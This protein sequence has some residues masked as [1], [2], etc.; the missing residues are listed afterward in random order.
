MEELIQYDL[1]TME[2][3]L[4]RV[5]AFF[6]A[7]GIMLTKKFAGEQSEQ[8]EEVDA[9]QRIK[10]FV[11]QAGAPAFY[12]DIN[13]PDDIPTINAELENKLSD[14]QSKL[15]TFLQNNS[16]MDAN[17][18]DK[19]NTFATSVLVQARK[20]I[21]FGLKKALLTNS[22]NCN[23]VAE[24][25][26]AAGRCYGDFLKKEIFERIMVPLYEGLKQTPKENA[27]LYV[28]GE[29]NNFLADLGIMTVDISVG[30]IYDENL[31]YIPAEESNSPQY[32]T[33]NE[34]EKGIVREILRYAYVFQEEKGEENC[35]IMEG[36][37]I[38]MIY[39]PEGKQ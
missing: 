21:R 24:L 13:S 1:A 5:K 18:A 22:K 6:L 14:L 39:R 36:E 12:L 28:L 3:L 29:L 20:A 8:A 7:K 31:P 11:I 30:E 37:V 15:K 26:T 16:D 17:L 38:V 33:T 2:N 19:I 35:Q 34:A 32:I 10:A 4:E 25:Q 23:T 27:Y 9:A